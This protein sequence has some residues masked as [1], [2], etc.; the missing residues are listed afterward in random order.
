MADALV[1][2]SPSAIIMRTIDTQKPFARLNCDKVY[3]FILHE[4]D[5]LEKLGLVDKMY[6]IICY[7]LF[8]EANTED[9]WFHFAFITYQL[10]DMLGIEEAKKDCVVPASPFKLR[11][12]RKQWD[13]ICVK[14]GLYN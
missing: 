3:A 11:D 5:K 8:N 10:A 1:V 9:I 13:A 6:M 14:A 7:S 4:K 2:E 12:M